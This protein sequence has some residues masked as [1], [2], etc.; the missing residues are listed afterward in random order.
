[1]FVYGKKQGR[2]PYLVA[3]LLLMTYTYFTPDVTS[4]TVVGLAIGT[5]C[6]YAIRQGW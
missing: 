4:L 2:W 6:W 3:G 1:M 5:A